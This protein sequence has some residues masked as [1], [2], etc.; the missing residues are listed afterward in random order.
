[1]QHNILWVL[2]TCSCTST[3]TFPNHFT[4]SLSK[5]VSGLS[6]S[7]A[8]VLPASPMSC[9]ISSGTGRGTLASGCSE[10]L[11]QKWT[12]IIPVLCVNIVNYAE[13]W[14]MFLTFPLLCC[15]PSAD[16][17]LSP[18]PPLLSLEPQVF[19]ISSPPLLQ[20]CHLLVG[21]F[22]CLPIRHRSAFPPILAV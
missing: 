5:G 21:V 18:P 10:M 17:Y 1:M 7:D 4:H 6:S 8:R 9:A 13:K 11:Q 20:L 22:R 2:N 12:R 14:K 19:P 3:S 16:P 15:L